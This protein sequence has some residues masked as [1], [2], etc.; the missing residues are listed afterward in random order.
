M[1]KDEAAKH[2]SEKQSDYM[3]TMSMQIVLYVLAAVFLVLLVY[4]WNLMQASQ[5]KTMNGGKTA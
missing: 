2:R 1:L 5:K 4:V 3:V